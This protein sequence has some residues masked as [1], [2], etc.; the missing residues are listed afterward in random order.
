VSDALEATIRGVSWS[1]LHSQ[2][3]APSA[4]QC[5]GSRADS[6]CQSALQ[7]YHHETPKTCHSVAAICAR[8][9]AT[10]TEQASDSD[11]INDVDA[12]RAAH[13]HAASV[14]D[15]GATTSMA[16]GLTAVQQ[17]MAAD[18]AMAALLVGA[19]ATG[20]MAA[21]VYECSVSSTPKAWL[22]VLRMVPVCDADHH[23][24][25]QCDCPFSHSTLVA[26]PASLTARQ[27]LGAA[28]RLTFA[29]L[30]ARLLSPLQPQAEEEG[31]EV[32]TAAPSK[33]ALK[34]ARKRA[35]A[36]AAA[37]TSGSA[38]EGAAG[39]PSTRIARKALQEQVPLA[40]PTATSVAAAQDSVQQL[41]LQ[42]SEADSRASAESPAPE[43]ML[44]PLTHAVFAD[45]VLCRGDG[46]TYERSA[47]TQWLAAADTSP[48]TGQ[49]LVSRDILPNHALRSIIQAAR[50]RPS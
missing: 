16:A 33:A 50:A 30:H 41:R 29:A 38:T 8:M 24:H 40:A 28:L 14:S 21:S 6:A 17:Q 3:L 18:A 44:C 34:R 32:A 9:K 7:N 45:P 27:P 47:I 35:A 25:A 15:G 5:C 4:G 22:Y 26:A 11:A 12:T 49:P 19:T 2:V 36:A 39:S 43:W 48:V 46:Q 1:H 10:E 23:L 20:H 13:K 31:A 37:A 42:D